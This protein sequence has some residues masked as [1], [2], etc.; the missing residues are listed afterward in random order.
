M[1]VVSVM[2]HIAGAI[3]QFLAVLLA[4]MLAEEETPVWC[5][6]RILIIQLQFLFPSS[7][8]PPSHQFLAELFPIPRH[9]L[10]LHGCAE[11]LL[12]GRS[13]SLSV[14]WKSLTNCSSC[15]QSSCSYNGF[16]SSS[17]EINSMH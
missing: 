10:H 15:S 2:R 3:D 1:I 4:C 14:L 11:R 13:P 16:S 7:S 9:N 12:S 17:D 6:P 5:D 8:S